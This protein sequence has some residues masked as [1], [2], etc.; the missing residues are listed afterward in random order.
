VKN[1][2]PSKRHREREVSETLTGY[3]IDL[4]DGRHVF[5]ALDD[6]CFFIRFRNAEGEETR[7]KLS[8]EAGDALQYLLRPAKDS[9]EI[10][11]SWLMHMTEAKK[12]SKPSFEW[13]AIKVDEA[14]APAQS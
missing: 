6:D 14:V 12:G 9:P 3:Q 13:Q 4:S 8:K 11:T 7:M 10:V 1:E 2:R 5:V